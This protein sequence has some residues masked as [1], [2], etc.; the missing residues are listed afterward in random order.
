MEC[1]VI[2]YGSIGKRHSLCLAELG[3]SVELV[4]AQQINDYTC[5][6]DLDEAL[7][8]N[9]FDYVVIANQTSM[10]FNTLL[11]LIDHN[12]QGIVL[13][14]KP[15]Y[16]KT[17]VLP[18]NNINKIL[19]AYNLRFHDLLVQTEK[20]LDQEE[21]I[22]F[23]AY[24][25]QYLPTWR[26]GA[27]YR[28]CYSAHKNK[29]GGVLRDLSHEID[30]ALWLCGHCLAITSIGGQ[31]SDLE[32]D[33]DDVY[34]MMMR[35]SRCPIVNLQVNYLDRV[36]KREILINTNKH[37]IFIDFIKGTLNIDGEIQIQSTHPMSQ[38]YFLQHQAV[39]RKDFSNFCDYTQGLYIT[40]LIEKIEQAAMSRSWITCIGS[41][42]M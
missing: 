36:T 35:C 5:Y 12:Y 22:T 8:S 31:F 26:Q 32:I 20:I 11:K 30:Y 23:S 16:S 2:G 14:E 37:T 17:E 38:T 21:L 3:C 39:I 13:V 40:S 15:L 18:L 24:V 1:L 29:G 4:T 34:S 7:R 41:N 25:G 6:P 28:Q 42:L 10:H 27:D 33:S 19:V 9:S